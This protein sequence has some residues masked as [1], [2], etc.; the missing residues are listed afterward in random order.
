[1]P[2]PI[3]DKGSPERDNHLH[4]LAE[5][6]R[7]NLYS[8]TMAADGGVNYGYKRDGEWEKSYL[9]HEE[10][11]CIIEW[12][13]LPEEGEDFPDAV[14]DYV[15]ALLADVGAFIRERCTFVVTPP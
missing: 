7:A 1:M 15:W 12:R 14:R 9:S 11:L 2:A 4:V 10:I 6:V 13:P 3:P 5:H 8:W